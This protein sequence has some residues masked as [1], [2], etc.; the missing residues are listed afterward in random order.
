MMNIRFTLR[1]LQKILDEIP[2]DRSAQDPIDLDFSKYATPCHVKDF[3]NLS[4]EYEDAL[5]YEA[6]CSIYLASDKVKITVVLIM[7]REYEEAFRAYQGGDASFLQKCCLRRELYCHEACH[8]IAIVRAFSSNRSSKV[9]EEFLERIKD[10]FTKSMGTAETTQT[11]R[12]ADADADVAFEREGISPSAFERDHFRYGDDDLNY[13]G[14]YAEL[15]L[16]EDKMI[17]AAKSLSTI[18][19][20]RALTYEDV[21]R[22][23]FVSKDFLDLFPEKRDR[24]VELI[25]EELRG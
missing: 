15:M 21:A 16:P 10:K 3:F 25:A 23:T 11:I 6:C 4:I 19:E 12:W 8:V 20:E 24:L 9:M 14:V 13:F 7:N 5:P 1:A 17:E 18:V 22:E 2:F